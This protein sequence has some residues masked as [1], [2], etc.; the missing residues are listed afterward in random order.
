MSDIYE[1]IERLGKLSNSIN[2]LLK[3]SDFEKDLS[4]CSLLQKEYPAQIDGI[5]RLAEVYES[6]GKYA[7]AAKYY[8]KSAEF[9]VKNEGFDQKSIDM[10]L[11]WNLR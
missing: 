6:M 4:V 1:D 8:Y 9:A 3:K 10:F 7:K 5:A 11:E 2:D